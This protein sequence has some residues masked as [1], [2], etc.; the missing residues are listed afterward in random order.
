MPLSTSLIEYAYGPGEVGVPLTVM[1][2]PVVPLKVS[3]A[4]RTPLATDQVYEGVP[5]LAVH[6][7]EYAVPV[8]PGPVAGV[9]LIVSGGAGDV[10]LP[11]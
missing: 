6:V 4:G 7:A 11:V 3:P 2:V 10:T 5:P 8:C 1:L 9:Q